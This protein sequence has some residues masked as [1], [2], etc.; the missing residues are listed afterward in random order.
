MPARNCPI[1]NCTYKTDDVEDILAAAMLQGH[2]ITHNTPP[3]APSNSHSKPEGSKRPTV[4][5]GITTEEWNY[6]CTRWNNYK[7]STNLS[8]NNITS[9]LLDCCDETLLTR[10][11][12][13]NGDL[14]GKDEAIVLAAIKENVVMS[15]NLA[16]SQKNLFQ[17]K[18]DRDE[19]IKAFVARLRGLASMCK[20]SHDITCTHAADGKH[21]VSFTDT[22]LKYVIICNIANND[23]QAD[24]LSHTNQ[25]LSLNE[26]IQ[27]IEAKEAGVK[28]KA[29]LNDQSNAG[30]RS[31]YKKEAAKNT[32]FQ[33]QN[34]P[35]TIPPKPTGAPTGNNY[36]S[37]SGK[38]GQYDQPNKIN[39]NGP[40]TGNK[41]PTCNYCGYTGH[42]DGSNP[43][44]RGSLMSGIWETV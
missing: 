40:G 3:P 12:R 37:Y 15:E 6:F 42:G 14:Y 4:S 11:F 2:F 7:T 10:L 25:D 30:I 36:T 21:T 17:A 5:S 32:N 39:H 19:P 35:T 33:G 18:Q 43:K 20:L 16:V 13:E 8:G 29:S 26:L 44:K 34:K 22:L 24:I 28:S 31:S 1:P 38:S 9:Q 27:F 41:G 23:I